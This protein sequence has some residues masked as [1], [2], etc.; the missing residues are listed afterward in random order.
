M[1]RLAGSVSLIIGGVFFI[2]LWRGG[3][4]SLESRHYQPASILVI[5][6]LGVRVLDP[7]RAIAVSSR[8]LTGLIVLFSCGSLIQRYTE[9]RSLQSTA[10]YNGSEGLTLAGIPEPVQRELEGLAGLDHSII[11][12]YSPALGSVLYPFLHPTS[13]LIL[14]GNVMEYPPVV[15]SYGRVSRAYRDSDRI[16]AQYLRESFKGYHECEWIC[17][18][19]DGWVIFQAGGKVA[20]GHS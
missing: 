14:I 6:V 2:L 19:L 10:Y 7:G 9:M 5:L 1:E 16:Q 4:I 8:I 17:R 15:A 18:Y 13:R 20:P 12:I 3:T 11:A